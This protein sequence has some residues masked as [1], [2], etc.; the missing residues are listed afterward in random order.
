VVG[1]T[2]AAATIIIIQ[3]IRVLTNSIGLL[4]ANTKICNKYTGVFLKMKNNEL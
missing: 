2:A 4:Q 1:T 3:F